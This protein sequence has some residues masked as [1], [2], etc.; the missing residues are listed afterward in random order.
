M[1]RTTLSAASTLALMIGTGCAVLKAYNEGVTPAERLEECRLLDQKVTEAGQLNAIGVFLAGGAGLTAGLKDGNRQAFGYV[2]GAF[3]LFAALAQYMSS[4]Q[5]S[6]FAS[7]N[8]QLILDLNP[9]DTAL[10]N[11]IEQLSSKPFVLD[12]L[13]YRRDSVKAVLKARRPRANEPN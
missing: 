13:R 9:Q 6:R 1:T 5:S 7:R 4:R 12:S 3:G 2:S 8:C 11:A 10:K